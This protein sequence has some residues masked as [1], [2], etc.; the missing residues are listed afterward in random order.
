MI[1]CDKSTNPPVHIIN[2][3]STNDFKYIHNLYTE[4]YPNF[5]IEKY[6]FKAKM[7]EN[8]R[9]IKFHEEALRQICL[10][11]RMLNYNITHDNQSSQNW[12]RLNKGKLSNAM[13]LSELYNYIFK[14]Q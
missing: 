5:L 2:I 4:L 13:V 14:T 10:K 7:C 11:H 9:D 12:F 8:D 3:G 1:G 6:A